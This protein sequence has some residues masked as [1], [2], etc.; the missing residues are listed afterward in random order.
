M[1]LL[2]KSGPGKLIVLDLF[3]DRLELAKQFGADMVINP[4]KE[5][6]IAIVKEL[7]DGY[8][9]DIYIEATGAQKNQ[10]SK[11]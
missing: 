9:C 8:G 7:T 4:A 11:A 5:D 3:E 10:L 6:A 2:K 1:G